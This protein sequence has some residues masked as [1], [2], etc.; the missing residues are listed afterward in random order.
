MQEEDKKEGLL[1]RLKHIENKTEDKQ[2]KQ[3]GI[4]SV[5]DIFDEQLTQKARDMLINLGN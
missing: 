1:K 4:K 2:S 5:I 3:L